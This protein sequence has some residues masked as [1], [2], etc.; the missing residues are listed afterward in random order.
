ME[1]R[2]KS[3]PEEVAD[4]LLPNRR[5]HRRR[6]EL[7]K[8]YEILAR[9]LFRKAFPGN[10]FP[11]GML[12]NIERLFQGE[13]PGSVTETYMY[14]N[15]EGFVYVDIGA[16]RLQYN[17]FLI[18]VCNDADKERFLQMARSIDTQSREGDRLELQRFDTDSFLR[19]EAGWQLV[20]E[21]R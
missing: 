7:D 12:R 21:R 18:D 2:L 19:Q 8:E 10:T 15:I 6:E 17:K 11:K 20:T 16:P 4:R 13:A 3:L 14:L 1:R 9:V 5:E